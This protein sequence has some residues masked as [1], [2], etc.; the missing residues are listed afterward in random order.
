[1]FNL[2]KIIKSNLWIHLPKNKTYLFIRIIKS[3]VLF[4]TFLNLATPLIYKEHHIDILYAKEKNEKT[5]NL[6]IEGMTCS[7]CESAI[8]KSVKK[9]N[10]IKDIQPNHKTGKGTVKFDEKQ[11]SINDVI[12]SIEKL[13]YKVIKYEE[14]K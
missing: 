4:I 14:I 13:G 1:M 11:V 9:L 2:S 7:S 8:K 12:K 10:G 5:Y 3:I 6:T